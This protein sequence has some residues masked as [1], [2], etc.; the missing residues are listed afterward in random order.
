[1]KK[2]RLNMELSEPLYR[3]L[4]NLSEREG[5]TMTE[6]VRRALSVLKAFDEQRALGNVHL[7]FAAKADQLD[8]ELVGILFSEAAE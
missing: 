7:G 4:C 5:V 3:Y 8:C 1:M 6:I 2:T